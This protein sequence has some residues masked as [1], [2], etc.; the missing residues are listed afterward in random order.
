MRKLT[1][2]QV[3]HPL[4]DKLRTG[5]GKAEA[6]PRA[7]GGIQNHAYES[8][9]RIDVAQHQLHAALLVQQLY[10]GRA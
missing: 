9:L 10:V 6:H 8:T 3:G 5:D 4:A 1:S 2:W 7:R